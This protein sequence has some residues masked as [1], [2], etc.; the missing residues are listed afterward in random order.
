MPP[1]KS[2]VENSGTATEKYEGFT[3]EKRAAMKEQGVEE[4]PNE[5]RG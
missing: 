2:P 3:A 4:P 1:T 5:N